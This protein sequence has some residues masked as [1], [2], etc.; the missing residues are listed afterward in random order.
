MRMASSS[1]IGMISMVSPRT[2]KLPREKST[3]LRW[4]CMETNLRMSV[5]RL[6]C[7]PTW[8]ATI[9]FMYC[10]GWPRP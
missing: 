10:S 4:Y 5:S 1:Y 2:R 6:I 9:A 8:S 3:S 7:I